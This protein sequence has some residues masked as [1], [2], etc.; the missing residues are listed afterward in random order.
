MSSVL[1][2]DTAFDEIFRRIASSHVIQDIWRTAFG[3]EYPEQASPFSFVTRTEMRALSGAL[4]IAASQR[5]VDLGCGCGGPG[6]VIAGH[7][8]AFLDGVDTSA[9]ATMVA[10]GEAVRLGMSGR[11]S[12]HVADAA[13]TGLPGASYAGA[14]SV[15]ALQL[16]PQPEAVISE[17]AR[18]LSPGGIFAFTTWCLSEPWR[19]RVVIS[20]YRRVLEQQGFQVLSY[21]EPIGWRERQ[22]EVYQLTRERGAQLEEDLGKYVTGLLVAEA[23][24]APEAIT[25]STRVVVAA[26]L[27]ATNDTWAR[28]AA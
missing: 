17:V 18:L 1:S 23:E 11:A 4:K 21:T 14:L 10:C 13:A 28:N 16:M 8:G 27:L 20:D 25:K 2:D 22:L 12:F 6:L 24:A 9:V 15:D 3:D 5:L 7:A 26:R 19:N